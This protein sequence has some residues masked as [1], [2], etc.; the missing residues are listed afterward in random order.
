MAKIKVGINGFGR[1]GRMVFNII[2]RNCDDHTKNTA[3]RLKQGGEWELAPAYDVCYAY[4]PDSVWVSQHA[5]SIN[6]KRKDFEKQDLI[7]FAKAMNIKK[8][9]HIINQINN[10]VKHWEDYADAVNVNSK[11][12]DSIKQNLL[13]ID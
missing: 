9:D 3:F 8:P 4:R 5:L 13:N 2:A 11:L 1:I 10:T 7:S 12:R 6:G